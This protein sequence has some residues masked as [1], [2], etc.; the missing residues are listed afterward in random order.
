MSDAGAPMSE[1][2]ASSGPESPGKKPRHDDG[3]TVAAAP[4]AGSSLGLLSALGLMLAAGFRRRRRG[5]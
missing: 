5:Q 1:G 4:T 2:G 3:C